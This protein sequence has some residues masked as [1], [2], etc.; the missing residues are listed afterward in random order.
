MNELDNYYKQ[1]TGNLSNQE[2]EI[3]N[4]IKNT[5]IKFSDLLSGNLEKLK[6]SF[7]SQIEKEYLD[8]ALIMFEFLNK[9]ENISYNYLENNN[10][11]EE[12]QN[13]EDKAKRF[14]KQNKIETN[15]ENNIKIV[16]KIKSKNNLGLSKV[17]NNIIFIPQEK[18]KLNS[19]NNNIFFNDKFKKY[20]ENESTLY[21][22][23][24]NYIF[25]NDLPKD[26]EILYI[27]SKVYDIK[28]ENFKNKEEFYKNF[29]NKINEYK[30]NS[31]TQ[32]KKLLLEK[33]NDIF[34]NLKKI[35]KEDI[36]FSR[37]F[38]YFHATEDIEKIALLSNQ[39][40]YE[41][42]AISNG[43]K[44]IIQVFSELKNFVNSEIINIKKEINS[45]ILVELAKDYKDEGNIG[46]VE[47]I[48]KIREK[49][50][51]NELSVNY[52][53]FENNY[54]NVNLKEYKNIF[55]NLLLKEL[56]SRELKDII[57]LN[58]KNFVEKI[59]VDIKNFLDY[60]VFKYKKDNNRPESSLLFI[61][62]E[63]KN[64]IINCIKNYINKKFEKNENENFKIN[65]LFLNYYEK[66]IEL[67]MDYEHIINQDVKY[68]D[69]KKS[70]KNINQRTLRHME[71]SSF[72]NFFFGVE[73]DDSVK[74][75]DYFDKKEP[76]TIELLENSINDLKPIFDK[77]D[78]KNGFLR[79]RKM[80]NIT[81]NNVPIKSIFLPS[82][83]TIALDINEGEKSYRNLMYEIGHKLDFKLNR[84]SFSDFESIKKIS[85]VLK[86]AYFR[87]NQSNKLSFQEKKELFNSNLNTD[88]F[89]K[90]FE[91]YLIENGLIS[92]FSP[93]KENSLSNF[94][95]LD[96]KKQI[97]D[98]MEKKINLN[99]EIEKCN[100]NRKNR[101]S[102]QNQNK[103]I[104]NKNKL[105]KKEIKKEKPLKLGENMNYKLF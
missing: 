86:N 103:E 83:N 40:N 84:P 69:L 52:C 89:A 32:T 8:S 34:E 59:N 96:E 78:I 31:L 61:N 39:E 58:N 60:E 71:D 81:K 97:N 20:V 68:G 43:E 25:S 24:K 67:A 91:I 65:E 88:I 50:L 51:E 18:E 66:S 104:I 101:I 87:A 94:M 16:K 48:L 46:M 13:I 85:N 72:N 12:T 75:S 42:F 76:E 77:L 74:F 82:A 99:Q 36:N 30:K 29:E 33:S 73:F 45:N 93:K 37:K 95:T 14:L 27:L 22:E 54:L 2:I 3:F 64:L 92:D 26:I 28:I 38:S 79:F 9:N 6:K 10:F 63:K 57:V 44:G 15:I 80:N 5:K 17:T 98:Y 56:D 62:K 4:E 1:I 100:E 19:K 90:A 21:V 105:I 53:E 23:N 102:L 49:Y 41:A 35:S 7:F 11:L 70:K 55:E 47:R